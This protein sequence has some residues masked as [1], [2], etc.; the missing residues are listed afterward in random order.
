MQ[1]GDI[2]AVLLAAG[3]GVRF[4]SGIPKVMHYL[5]D[6]PMIYYPVRALIRS[7]I[8]DIIVVLGF[9][10]ET[11]R[12]YLTNEF[13][14]IKLKFVY[15]RVQR[16]TGDAVKIALS[17]VKAS[18]F[19]LLYGDMPLID[20]TV[21][22]ELLQF[23]KG[24][25]LLL[26]TFTHNNPEGYGRVIRDKDDNLLKIVE[27]KDASDAERQV[28]EVNAGLYLCNTN[29]VKRY[30]SRISNKNVQKEYYFTDI[31]KIAINEHIP[32]RIF[33]SNIDYL[34]GSN[35]RLELSNLTKTLQRR[36]NERLMLSGVSIIEPDSVFVGIDVQIDRDTTIYPNVFISG[37]SVI[38]RNV[39]I[40]NGA[41]IQN[42]QIGDSVHI[43]PYSHI[44]KAV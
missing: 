23:S 41:I 5:I 15:Q 33:E 19:I 42:S 14:D 40:E 30:I 3:K 9:G 26:T 22:T 32:I 12:E 2:S 10:A 39:R 24:S 31:F 25:E 1:R 21:I 13:G 43:K 37:R 38:G 34:L 16:G 27:H 44:E 35:N 29:I 8:K 20:E 36:I 17:S 11:V 4:K 7:G 28:L 6:R 18:K